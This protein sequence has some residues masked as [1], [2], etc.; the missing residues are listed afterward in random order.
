MALALVQAGAAQRDAV[1]QGHILADLGRLADHHA[2][3]VV[4]EQARADRRAGM[5]FDAGQAAHHLREPA[6]QQFQP[7]HPQPVCD[8]VAPDG[9]QAGIAEQHFQQTARGRVAFEHRLD[10]AAKR[11]QHG[12]IP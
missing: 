11:F 8:A 4:D 7:V 6:R 10:I 12:V 5:D 2:H 3:A 9:V 1:I